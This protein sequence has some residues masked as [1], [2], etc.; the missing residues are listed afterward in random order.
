MGVVQ[1]HAST[2]ATQALGVAE[3]S[4]RR[5]KLGGGALLGSGCR[6]IAG[7]DGGMM[8][9]TFLVERSRRPLYGRY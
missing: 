2:A 9:K 3:G 7:H 8:E 4:L 5:E 1:R 6:E